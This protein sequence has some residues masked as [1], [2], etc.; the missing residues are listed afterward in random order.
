S[1]IHDLA[2]SR[3][4]DRDV[5]A[6]SQQQIDDLQRQIREVNSHLSRVSEAN[7][8]LRDLM[9]DVSASIA[10]AHQEAARVAEMQRVEEQRL[11]RQ[12]VELQGLFENLRQQFTEIAAKSQR[13][14]DV[15]HQLN[16][17]IEAVENQLVPLYKD[18]ATI[19]NDLERI[20]RLSTE[21]YVGQQE[22]LE[23]LRT[24]I[25]AQLSEQ[26]QVG[27]QRIDRFTS[28]LSA[29]DERLRAIEQQLGELPSRFAA[30]EQRDEVIGT[31]ADSMEEW[32][33]MR[34]LAALE[35]VLEDVRKRRNERSATMSPNPKPKPEEAPGSIY[36]PSGLLKSVRDAK[37]PSRSFSDVEEDD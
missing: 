2:E 8:Q 18:E 20:E 35:E 15:R 12:G 6:A 21:Q 11:R 29:V 27:D 4:T 31:E 25:E 33:V 28:R 30:L 37:P 23:T 1:Q 16:E 32:L 17:R 22:R 9:E 10:E 36:N 24:Q 7:R 13:V 3:K 34:Q 26:R 5:D 19:H 14:D